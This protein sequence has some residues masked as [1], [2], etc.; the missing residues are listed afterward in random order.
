MFPKINDIDFNKYSDRLVPIIIQDYLTSKVLMLGYMNE[1][2]YMLSTEK[3][4]VHFYSRS[5]NRI[6]LK[7]ES[8]SNFLNLIDMNLDC[9]QDALIA[10]VIPEGPTCHRNTES[11]FD[12]LDSGFLDSLSKLIQTRFN[13]ENEN[14]YV[15]SLFDKGLDKIA[16]KVGEEAVETVIASKND[17]KDEFIS[18]SSDLLFHLL[19]LLKYKGH[20]FNDLVKCLYSRKK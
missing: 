10:Q 8:S 9:D 1:E 11:C 3:M 14:S 18:E 13:E 16:Q 12:E 2:A 5:K 7:G 17:N 19:I 4:K 20:D 6:W 15:R